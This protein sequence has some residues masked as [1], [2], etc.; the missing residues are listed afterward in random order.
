MFSSLK[1]KYG[2]LKKQPLRTGLLTLFMIACCA[3]VF[4]FGYIT[5]GSERNIF[6][7]IAVLG[8]LPSAKMI[9]SFIMYLKNEKYAVSKDIY[10]KVEEYIKGKDVCYGYDFYLTSYKQNFCINTCFIFDGSLVCLS[11]DKKSNAKDI[12]EHIEK[13]MNQ[14][15][16][17]GYKIYILD[18]KEKYYDR[19]KSVDVGYK[20]SESDEKLYALMKNL[21]L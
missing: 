1:G 6:T 21:A 8:I 20:K 16:I 14:N 4:L 19:I 10:E 7:I 9:V 15:S 12:K 5:R 13:Y 17:D 18:N 2:Y 3:A 11:E